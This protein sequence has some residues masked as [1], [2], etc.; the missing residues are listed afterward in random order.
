MNC[1]RVTNVLA[2]FLDDELPDAESSAVA[3]HLEDCPACRQQVEAV[4][5]LPPIEAPRLAADVEQSLFGEF[6]RC[7]KD[8]IA[9]SISLME[10]AI[11]VDAPP[12]A[13]RRSGPLAA[14]LPSSEV[15]L[16]PSWVV[17]YLGVVLMLA[18]GVALN[19]AQVQELEQ[20]V[21]RR[22]SLIDALQHQVQTQRGF[23]VGLDSS[24]TLG[25]PLLSS[26]APG[27][28]PASLQLGGTTGV[29]P[30]RRGAFEG[31]RVVH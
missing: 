26:A 2:P 18:A 27:A 3:S 14:L 9:A 22:D 15:R 25:Q 6:D 19:H 28:A 4:A 7:L 1:W 8:R 17:A 13:V 30:F 24:L 16:R 10:P 23:A 21:A 5:A 12:T 29:L 11:D 31:P 20:S